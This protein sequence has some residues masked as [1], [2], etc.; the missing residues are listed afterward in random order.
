MKISSILVYYSHDGVAV[1]VRRGDSIRH[2]RMY[3][4]VGR[5]SMTRLA[6]TVA[7]A[8]LQTELSIVV[9]YRDGWS[10]YR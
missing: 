7:N 8:N 1:Y 5:S 9:P 2:S 3:R 4:S 10:W 6:D